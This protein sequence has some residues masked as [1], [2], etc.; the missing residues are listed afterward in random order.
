MASTSV[1]TLVL[2]IAAITVAVGV[3]GTLSGTVMH[4]SDSITD[5]GDVMAKNIDTDV[6]VISD[7]G[8]T[9]VY[10][11]GTDEVTILLK[12]TGSGTI[13]NTT[14]VVDVLVDGR[15]VSGGDLNL[16]V[17]GTN[18]WREDDVARLTISNQSL[19]PG[20]HRVK[21]VVN[22]DEELFRFHI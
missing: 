4:I 2:F 11:G 3:A 17:L 8:S 10:D 20:D 9:A 19:G 18:S 14:D 5:R 15:Y 16:T 6:E 12:N 1:S 13:P 7:A 22:E 21:V